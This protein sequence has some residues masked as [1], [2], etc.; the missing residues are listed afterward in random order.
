MKKLTRQEELI[1]FY[2]PIGSWITQDI[3]LCGQEE[4]QSISGKRIATHTTVGG[5]GLVGNL[6]KKKKQ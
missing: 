6:L 3:Y 4:R 2:K 5:S 1:R